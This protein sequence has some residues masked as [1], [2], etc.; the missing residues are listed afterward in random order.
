VHWHDREVV[1]FSHNELSVARSALEGDIPG[2]SR[3]SL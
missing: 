1:A 3:M 2:R